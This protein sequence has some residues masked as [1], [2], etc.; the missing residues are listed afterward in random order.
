MIVGQQADELPDRK[1]LPPAI[2]T[3]NTNGATSA[4]PNF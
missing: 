4:L 3:R 2:E 1:R